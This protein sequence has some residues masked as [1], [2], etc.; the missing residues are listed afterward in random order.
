MQSPTDIARDAAWEGVFGGGGELAGRAI[1]GL[2]GRLIKG[3]RGL[4]DATIEQ[5]EALRAQAREI[6]E[7]GYRPT[8]AG[9]TDESFRP[10]LNRLQAVYE[11]VFPNQKA[12]QQNLDTVIAELRARG[13]VD[14]SAINNLDAVVKNDIDNYYKTVD[15]KLADAQ[16]RMDDAVREK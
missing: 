8:V 5:T 4:A 3:P 14:E 10:I 1:S 9:A 15:Q 13:V 11:G 12:A 6:I 7:K 2:F 16:V